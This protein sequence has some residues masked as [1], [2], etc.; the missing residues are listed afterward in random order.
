MYTKLS[1]GNAMSMNE[2]LRLPYPM[3]MNFIITM[4]KDKEQEIK[5]QKDF[6]IKQRHKLNNM[7]KNKR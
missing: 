3:Y 5:K 1:D 6:E 4:I 2:I 7:R